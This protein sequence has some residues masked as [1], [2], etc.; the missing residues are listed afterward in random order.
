MNSLERQPLPPTRLFCKCSEG[1]SGV[2]IRKVCSCNTDGG[3]DFNHKNLRLHVRK[4]SHIS[5]EKYR[6]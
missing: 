5:G 1:Q 2:R 4:V 3:S 6:K